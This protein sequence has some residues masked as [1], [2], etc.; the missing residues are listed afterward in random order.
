MMK[1]TL[2]GGPYIYMVYTLYILIH[3]N[4]LLHQYLSL[5]KQTDFNH[6]ITSVTIAHPDYDKQLTSVTKPYS[7]P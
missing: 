7:N 1:K 2:D 5:V 3:F 6:L 4:K